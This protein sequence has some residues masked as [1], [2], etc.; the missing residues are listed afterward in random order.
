MESDSAERGDDDRV[1]AS[2]V[3][4]VGG[5]TA[6]AGSADRSKIP[7]ALRSVASA[8]GEPILAGE[9]KKAVGLIKAGKDI[10]YKGVTG[11]HEFDAAGDVAGVVAEVVIKNGA[12]VETGLLD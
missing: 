9:W 1:V 8:P 6:G 2:S 3:G 10:D 7:A 11:D 12:F 4:H 5:A